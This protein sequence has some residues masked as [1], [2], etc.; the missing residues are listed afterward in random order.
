MNFYIVDAFTSKP[1]GG[2]PAGVVIYENMSVEKMQK[3][4]S[5][6]R[7]S[8]TAFTKQIE[9]YKFDIR[10]FTQNSEVPL[11]GHATIASF[12]ALLDSGIISGNGMYYIN[13]KSGML[14]VYVEDN[15]ILMKQAK[16]V[17]R[18]EIIDMDSIAKSLNISVDDI[19]D[20][21][22]KLKPMIV[23]TGLFDIMLPV[24][25]KAI[26]NSISPDF[27][28]LSDLSSCYNVVGIH[29][30]T[31]ENNNYTASCRNFA[32]L[33]GINE[34]AATGTA[35]GALTYYLYI[36]GVIKEFNND[37]SFEQGEKMNRTSV[38][39]TRMEFNNDI[40][41]LC[42]GSYSIFSR[43]ELAV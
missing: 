36:N 38:I 5:E 16:P 30:F 24:K 9:A 7:Y 3:I 4:A 43:G 37:Y 1:F 11:C 41:I 13:T 23:S 18:S 33:Y 26:L 15:F 6:L 20:Y 34:E 32:P 28:A 25:N 42:G 35:N 14:P 22:F 27:Q 40:E 19:G 10:F 12:G 2:N 8:E 29:A 39:N 17:V 31:L 21:N